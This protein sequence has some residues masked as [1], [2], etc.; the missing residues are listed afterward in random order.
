MSCGI[1]CR[2]GLDPALLWCKSAAIAPIWPLTWEP[3]YAVGWAPKKKKNEKRNVLWGGGGREEVARGVEFWALVLLHTQGKI[4]NW[5]CWVKGHVHFNSSY[6]WIILKKCHTDLNF[7]QQKNMC[8]PTEYCQTSSLLI[9]DQVIENR[10]LELFSCAYSTFSTGSKVIIVPISFSFFLFFFF[11]HLFRAT[12]K[13]YGASPRQGSNQ[14][15]SCWPTP[16]QRRIPA[17]SATYTTT[18]RNARSLTHWARPG[19]ESV[20]SWILVRFFSTEPWRKHP[21]SFSWCL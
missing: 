8:F 17:V 13:A 9:F 6:W 14:S 16:Q 4:P 7:H 11:F 19:I 21:I 12:L 2:H 20:Y 15:C 18:H 10:F 1:G 3:P 5:N